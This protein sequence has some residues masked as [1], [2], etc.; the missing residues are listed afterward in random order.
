VLTKKEKS[1]EQIIAKIE[2]Y[3]KQNG[4]LPNNLNDIGVI[5]KEEGPIFYK[6]Q[7]DTTYLIYYGGGLGESIIY[8]F[9]TKQW[10]SDHQ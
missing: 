3:K 1:G 4:H 8:N 5:E 10:E 9:E 2:A 6:K 7:T